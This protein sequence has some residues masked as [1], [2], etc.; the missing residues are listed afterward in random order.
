M[1]NVWLIIKREYLERVRTRAFLIFTVLMPLFI[2]GV[3]V[4]P[5]KLMTMKSGSTREIAVVAPT[6]EIA[7]DIKSQLENPEQDSKKSGDD[8]SIAPKYK[9]SV[10]E[11]SDDAT[12]A[13]LATEVSQGKLDAYVW[14]TDK[15]VKSGKFAY[16]TK[17]PSDFS[18]FSTVQSAVNRSLM[19]SRISARGIP[20]AEIESVLKRLD[21]DVS[22][23]DQTGK[24]GKP[25]GIAAFFLPFVLMFMIYM[26]VLIYGMVVM[27]SVLQ[28]K[29]SRVMEVMLS[30]VSATQMMAGKLLGVG[31]VGITQ[32]L[33]WLGSTFLI[34]MQFGAQLLKNIN[35]PTQLFVYL[36]IFFLL[37]Y[38]L[39]STMYAAVGAMVNSEEEA[40][41][42]QWPVM[43]PLILCSVFASAVIRDPNSPLAIWSSFF[44][45][46]APIMMFVRIAVQTPPVWQIAISIGVQVLTI[47]GMV[48]VCARIYR[49]GILMYG[50]R[51]TLPE[52]MKW[53]KYA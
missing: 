36:P 42:L 31:A 2:G 53:I 33:I 10:R 13:Q 7:A 34:R 26:T 18:D 27:R 48:W 40:Q 8:D 38:L 43:M 14:L 45:F 50:K 41:Q 29:T 11:G 21:M 6:P 30:S 32:I 20:P 19:R 15:E 12:R 37:G 17:H 49:I 22:G 51:P 4:L 9:V 24:E 5:T 1:R 46:T 39:Y 25:V 3:I 35:L 44:P 47:W 16:I 28:E 52:I 23:V